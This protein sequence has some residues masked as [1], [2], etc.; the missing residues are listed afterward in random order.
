MARDDSG[1]RMLRRVV[2]MSLLDGV[3]PSAGSIG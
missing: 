1:D 3:R 2:V